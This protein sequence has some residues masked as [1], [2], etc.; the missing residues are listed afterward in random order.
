[1]SEPSYHPGLE[2]VIAGETA[3]STIAGGAGLRYR[4]YAIED[5]AREASFEEVAYL[6]LHGELP[7][8][9]AIDDFCGRLSAAAAPPDELLAFMYLCMD[10][11]MHVC[12]YVC[13]YACMYV[14]M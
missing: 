11:C 10:V 8:A 9:H 12:M 7:A 2:G 5:L 13:M 6:I 1:M 4:G 14:C 3:I